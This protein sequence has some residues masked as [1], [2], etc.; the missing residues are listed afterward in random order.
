M[1][2]INANIDPYPCLDRS[3]LPGLFSS[4]A[5]YRSLSER[6]RQMLISTSHATIFEPGALVARAK[7]TSEFWIGLTSGLLKLSVHDE[8][9]KGVTLCGISA[10]GWFG[11]GSVLK[12]E[13]R[14]YDVYSLQKSRVLMVPSSTFHSLL[15]ESISFNS[16]IIHQLNNRLAEFICSVQNT[17]MLTIT[18]RV[19]RSI[20]QLFNQDLYPSTKSRIY[21]SQEELAMLV[22]VSRQRVNG[23][24][25]HLE[26]L[27]LVNLSYNQI[28]VLDLEQMRLMDRVPTVP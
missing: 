23:A 15:D 28:D 26:R 20:A 7:C 17:R 19:A 25:Q 27:G 12:N 14:Q 16:F 2:Q 13:L 22:G 21:I 4:F 24:L 11:E 8:S 18:A 10:G 5:W 9:G 1:N 6:H 3:L